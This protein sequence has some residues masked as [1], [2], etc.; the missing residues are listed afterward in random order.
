LVGLQYAEQ[1]HS[2][3]SFSE[4]LAQQRKLPSELSAATD[5]Q[6]GDDI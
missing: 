6:V 1:V 2:L 3:L 5:N 4:D